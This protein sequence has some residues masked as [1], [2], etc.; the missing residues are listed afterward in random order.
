MRC[1]QEE[2]GVKIVVRAAIVLEGDAVVEVML[3]SGIIRICVESGQA[4]G[5]TWLLQE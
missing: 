4:G 3:P 5:K 1:R 2:G